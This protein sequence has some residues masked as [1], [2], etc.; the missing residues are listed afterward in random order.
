MTFVGYALRIPTK[1]G[2]VYLTNNEQLFLTDNREIIEHYQNQSPGS[3]IV[4][5]RKRKNYVS[6]NK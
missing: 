5:F 6:K 1:N 4:K 3:R 2:K